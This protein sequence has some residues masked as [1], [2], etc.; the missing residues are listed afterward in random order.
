M[1]VIFVGLVV[2]YLST[3]VRQANLMRTAILV[4]DQ[5]APALTMLARE[6]IVKMCCGPI[7]LFIMRNP[8]LNAFTFG[9]HDPKVIVLYS[10][11]FNEMD[12]DEIRFILGHEVGDIC[13]GHTWLNSIIGGMAGLPSTFLGTTMLRRIFLW[14]NRACE[15]SGDR[16]GLMACG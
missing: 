8:A 6:C 2:A 5:S 11:L 13:L 12:A 3:R 14:W 16:A 7:Q 15:Y 9:L 10:D 4:N 1:I